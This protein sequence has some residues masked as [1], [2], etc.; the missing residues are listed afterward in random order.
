MRSLAYLLSELRAE[1]G[2]R[3]VHVKAHIE[4]DLCNGTTRGRIG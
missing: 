4:A 2:V 1:V 3:G